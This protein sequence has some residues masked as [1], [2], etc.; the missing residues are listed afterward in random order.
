MSTNTQAYRA[1]AAKS[2]LFGV[3]LIGIVATL[4]AHP[5]PAAASVGFDEPLSKKVSFR[6]LDLTRE[7]DAK[8]LISRINRAARYVCTGGDGVRNYYMRSSVRSCMQVASSH[9]I[10]TVDSPL[11]TALFNQNAK[12]KLAQR[13]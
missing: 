5:Q 13:D 12:V 11:V 4:V 1:E 2:G 10:A 6:D 3:V 9:A 7:A 8:I